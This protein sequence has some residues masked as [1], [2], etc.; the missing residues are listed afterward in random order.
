M[1]NEMAYS[2]ID[3]E[4]RKLRALPYAELANRVGSNETKEVVATDGRTYQLEIEM[5]WD[6]GKNA[7][8]RVMV[9]ADDGGW[10]AFKPLTG[11]FIMASDGTFVGE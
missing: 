9:A 3:A 11:D 2:L 7:D 10:R 5:F 4:L 1:N 8:V 6:G